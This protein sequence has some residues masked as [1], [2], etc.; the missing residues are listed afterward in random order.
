MLADDLAQGKI[1]VTPR[2]SPDP[3]FAHSVIVLARYNSTGALGLMLQYR[4]DLT[5]RK[6][7]PNITPEAPIFIG[8]PVDLPVVLA[9]LRTKS[10][11]P[12]AG[13]VRARL[14]LLTSGIVIGKTL[15]DDPSASGLRIFL[16]YAGWGAGQLES[17]VRR[18]GWH[19]FDYDEGIVF[20]DHP[21]T[22]WDRLTEK[23]ERRTARSRTNFTHRYGTISYRASN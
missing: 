13:N 1:L 6:V 22:L 18:G 19:I 7:L 4:S 10:A 12:G 3:H 2:R 16:G 14:Y 9:L 11:P 5:T 21:D 8:G 17:E 15:A 20:D 23:T